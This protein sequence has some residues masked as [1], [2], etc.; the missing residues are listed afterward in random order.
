LCG[1]PLGFKNSDKN[2]SVGA[3]FGPTPRVGRLK[4]RCGV[5]VVPYNK[6]L[7]TAM[8]APEL[9]ASVRSLYSWLRHVFAHGG[10]AGN[11]LRG[12]LEG[13]GDD[14]DRQALR[15]GQRLRSTAS[16]LGG[17]AHHCLARP[18][19]PFGKAIEGSVLGST[20]VASTDVAA[21]GN[22]AQSRMVSILGVAATIRVRL[23]VFFA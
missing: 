8:V 12:A 6:F 7:P 23:Y 2:P 5:G 22:M 10:Y 4:D 1:W 3:C 21:S 19:S 13:L 11:K 17:G 20:S 16:S 14:R 18:Q 15:R 9:L